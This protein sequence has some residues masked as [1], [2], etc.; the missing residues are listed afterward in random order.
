MSGPVS[1]IIP[2]YNRRCLLSNAI[3]SVNSQTYKNIE[4]II[5]DDGSEEDIKEVVNSFDCKNIIY[6]RHENNKGGSVARNT[7]I[8]HAEGDYIAFLDSDDEWRLDKIE[9]QVNKIEAS[10]KD[11]DIVYCD[12][13]KGLSSSSQLLLKPHDLRE[14]DIH[15]DL[16]SG[17]MNIMTSQLLIKQ[18]CIEESGGFNPNFPSF[19]EY[20][21][22]VRMAKDSVVAYVD[23]RLVIKN[24]GRHDQ[25]GDDYCGR[26][27]GLQ[28]FLNEHGEDMI[29]YFGEDYIKKFSERRLAII[30]RSKACERIEQGKT[31]QAVSVVINEEKNSPEWKIVDIFPLTATLIAGERGRNLIYK[32]QFHIDCHRYGFIHKS[33]MNRYA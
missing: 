19:Q 33:E 24:T 5:V 30:Y 18:S 17:W 8:E 27:D 29:D 13:L 2:T 15:K 12:Y 32:V 16:L 22:L 26:F 4:I 10:D 11:I 20:D 21:M 31:Q 9:K 28:M 3:D 14:G 7:G 25:I 6:I 1:V 23:E